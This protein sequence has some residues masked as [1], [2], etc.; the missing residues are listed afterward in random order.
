V[1]LAHDRLE[2]QRI[3]WDYV[4]IVR[5]DFRL[6]RAARRIGVIAREVEEFY[7]RTRVTEALLELRN[8]TTVAALAVRCALKRR[9]SCGLHY[10]VACPAH[11]SATP[12][13]TVLSARETWKSSDIDWQAAMK[14]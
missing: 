8:I 5:S 10:N 6:K 2:V 12:K 11:G 1:L 14:F 7:K 9:E 3:M 13:D 4:G